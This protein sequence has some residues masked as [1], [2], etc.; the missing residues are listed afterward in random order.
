MGRIKMDCGLQNLGQCFQVR[1]SHVAKIIGFSWKLMITSCF[2]YKIVGGGGEVG[3][4]PFT[5][6][7]IVNREEKTTNNRAM[8]STLKKHC[9]CSS[10]GSSGNK[11]FERYRPSVIRPISSC[12]WSR[13]I[14]R[15]RRESYFNSYYS[16]FTTK[17]Q[18]LHDDASSEA[19]F[20]SHWVFWRTPGCLMTL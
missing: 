3:A 5:T 2:P 12:W 17:L 14:S 10:S 20:S 11:A 15:T 16:F 9:S 8:L 7:Y 19:I 18:N 1:P 4:A 6:S 13:C